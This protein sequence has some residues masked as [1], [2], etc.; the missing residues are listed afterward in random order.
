[1]QFVQ[2]PQLIQKASLNQK[3]LE[4]RKL[5]QQLNDEIYMKD[6]LK[7][8][9]QDHISQCAMKDTEI[10]KLQSRIKELVL[11][12]DAMD[13]LQELKLSY[14]EMEDELF[15]YKNKVLKLQDFEDQAKHQEKEINAQC[16]ELDKLRHE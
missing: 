15:K 6:E 5:K 11:L 8:T 16:E 1:M 7:F 4:I 10:A 3:E 12:Q 14:R 9:I 2:S 13:D